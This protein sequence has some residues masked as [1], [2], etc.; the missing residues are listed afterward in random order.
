LLAFSFFLSV[1]RPPSL[2]LS[3]FPIILIKDV[4]GFCSPIWR[5]TAFTG[6][7]LEIKHSNGACHQLMKKS[8]WFDII[9]KGLK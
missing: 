7:P 6:I 8:I 4:M 3:L 2:P 5:F 9:N 1:S